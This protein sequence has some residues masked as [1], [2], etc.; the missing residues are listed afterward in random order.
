VPLL[1]GCAETS[2]SASQLRSQ[3]SRICARAQARA[4]R[5]A[6]PSDPEQGERFLRAGI[7]ALRPAARALERLKPPA[8]LKESYGQAVGLN[9]QALALIERHERAIASGEDAAG[10]FHA[11]Q[12]ALD[13][14]T[15]IEASTWRALQIPA[16]VPR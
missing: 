15:R 10:A 7:A 6:L 2:L 3:A 4:N 9:A 5:I 11:L 16:C 13:P 12:A 1:G 8:D 14:V